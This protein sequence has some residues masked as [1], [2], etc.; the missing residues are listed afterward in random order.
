MINTEL[1]DLSSG[2]VA[3]SQF[4]YGCCSLKSVMSTS[5]K[6]LNTLLDV[7]LLQFRCSSDSVTSGTKSY[8]ESVRRRN[9]PQLIKILDTLKLDYCFCVCTCVCVGGV[10]G[11][12]RERETT[13]ISINHILTSVTT[14]EAKL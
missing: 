7:L 10:S 12:E 1:D 3:T 11:R 5:L 13:S 4:K 14:S 6:G 9:G 2:L 8:F